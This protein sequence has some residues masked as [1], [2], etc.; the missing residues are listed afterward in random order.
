MSDIIRFAPAV[1]EARLAAVL[2]AL[3]AAKPKPARLTLY[4]GAAPPAGAA[5]PVDVLPLLSFPLPS[6]A[7]EIRNGELL[8]AAINEQMVVRTGRAAFARVEDG[9]GRPVLDLD[10]S[11]FGGGGAV[12]LATVDLLAGSIV[13]VTLAKLT[14]N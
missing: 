3:D 10:I 8:L 14:E 2:T 12:Q 6:P 11:A 13:R 5:V 4:A 9:A 1:C 7:G